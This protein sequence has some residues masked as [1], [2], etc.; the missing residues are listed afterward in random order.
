M[1]TL[2]QFPWSPFAI[3]VRHILER[4]GIPF[5]LRDIPFHDRASIIAATKGRRHSVPC[6]ID[7]NHALCD[8]TDFG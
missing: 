1:L 8:T 2:I 6:I 4:N 7:G 3:T 5:R